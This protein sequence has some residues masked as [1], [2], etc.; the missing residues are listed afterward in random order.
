ME[1]RV[2]A[3]TLSWQ[4]LEKQRPRCLRYGR[5]RRLSDHL[6]GSIEVGKYAD[7]TVFDRD[8]MT[9]PADDILNAKVVMTIVGGKIAYDLEANP[10]HDE[11]PVACIPQDPSRSPTID[12]LGAETEPMNVLIA[13]GGIGGITAAL[14]LAEQAFELR[15]LSKH[16][17][18]Q[19][20]GLVFSFRRI[21]LEYC[22]IDLA[23]D[24][25][26]HGFLPEG[27]NLETGDLARSSLNPH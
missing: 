2:T 4:S 7:F 18:F 8:L 13:G 22:T 6:R 14:C 21:A 17:P 26:S 16:P 19:R 15:S 9:V 27:I 11:Q 24:L 25:L 10:N 12:T 5:L 23:Q 3:G 1:R 20:S